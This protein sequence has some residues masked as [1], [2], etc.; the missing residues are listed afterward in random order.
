[1]ISIWPKNLYIFWKMVS[2]FYFVNHFPCSAQ[3]K[4]DTPDWKKNL[5]P[6]SRTLLDDEFIGRGRG[7][8]GRRWGFEVGDQDVVKLWGINGAVGPTNGEF[9]R[10]GSSAG[11]YR[12][13]EIWS[14]NTKLVVRPMDL[15]EIVAAIKENFKKAVGAGDKVF[16]MLEIGWAQLD[17]SFKQLK[18]CLVVEKILV[19]SF[20]V[21]GKVEDD[22]QVT[23]LML[24]TDRN[25]LA[26]LLLVL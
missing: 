15:T 12:T 19:K 17:R 14:D 13:Q 7:S 16:E 10:R 26:W 2:L 22:E 1:M 18:S 9:K 6:P 24:K 5:R 8:G 23:N 25:C 20:W 21:L 11:S 3:K 4:L